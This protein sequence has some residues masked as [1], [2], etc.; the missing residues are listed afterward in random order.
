MGGAAHTRKHSAFALAETLRHR[1]DMAAVLLAA[2]PILMLYNPRLAWA[3]LMTAIVLSI[4]KRLNA[5]NPLAERRSTL[6]H[7][8]WNDD[9]SV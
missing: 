9:A 1:A 2:F 5:A 7:R 8:S 6:A 3:A 4:R